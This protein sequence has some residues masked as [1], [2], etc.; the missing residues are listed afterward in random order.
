MRLSIDVAL[1]S[2]LSAHDAALLMVDVVSGDG[3]V[4]VTSDLAVDQGTLT[5]VGDTGMVWARVPGTAL[6]LRYRAE[7]DIT[8]RATG[9]EGLQASPPETLL[10]EV[11]P[12]LRPSRYC[13]SD[14]FADFTAQQFGTLAGGAKIAAIRDWVAGNLSYIPGSSNGTTTAAET[15]CTRQGVCRDFTHMLCT[16]ARAAQIPSRYASAYGAEVAPQDFHAIAQVWL[17]GAWHPVDATNMGAPHE[18][19]V[20]ATGRDA[21]DVAFMETAHWAQLDFLRVAVSRGA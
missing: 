11:L 9:L 19:A 2:T 18:M 3:Q 6:A 15:F 14:M 21:A 4:V 13:P 5:R 1:N 17:E 8:R 12:Y 16:L 10:A 7:I 20:I